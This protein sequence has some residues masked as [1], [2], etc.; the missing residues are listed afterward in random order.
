MPQT[1]QNPVSSVPNLAAL[2]SVQNVGARTKYDIFTGIANPADTGRSFG[3]QVL[4]QA[5]MAAGSTVADTQALHSMHAYFLRPGDATAP[6]VF[7]VS[8]QFDGRSFSN[9]RSEAYQEG[10]VIFS[11]NASFQIPQ[12]GPVHAEQFDISAVPAPTEIPDLEVTLV[13]DDPRLTAIKNRPVDFRFVEGPIYTEA[14]APHT[15][16]H[17]WLR[18][19]YELPENQLLHRAALAFASDYLLIEPALRSTGQSWSTP[20]LKAASLDH[21]MWFYGDFRVDDWLLYVIDSKALGSNR[22]LSTGSF[23]NRE[24]KLVASVAQEAMVRISA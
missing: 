19:K 1:S 7:E 8:R 12:E 10:E 15:K 6:M 13:G 23:Y 20:D 9:R 21:A 14:L 22:N 16:Q 2:L 24:G 4:G 3:G 18:T 11:L 17:V 5:L